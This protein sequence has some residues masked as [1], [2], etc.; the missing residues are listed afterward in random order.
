[1]A[2]DGSD[3]QDS[4]QATHE[5]RECMACRGTGRV[6]SNL[7]GSPSTVECPWCAGSGLRPA[8]ID[9]QAHWGEQAGGSAEAPAATPSDAPDEGSQPPA[10][11]DADPG[12]SAA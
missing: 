5:P 11:A 12:D 4:G 3:T 1:V 7:G 9:A 2:G 10:G 6:I 8:E